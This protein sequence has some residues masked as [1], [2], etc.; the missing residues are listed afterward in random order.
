MSMKV[1][2]GPKFDW[3]DVLDRLIAGEKPTAEDRAAIQ[4][5]AGPWTTCAC[6]QMCK[7][8]PRDSSKSPIDEQLRTLGGEF[9]SMMNAGRYHDARKTLDKIEK[10]TTKLLTDMGVVFTLGGVPRTFR[11]VLKVVPNTPVTEP[12]KVVKPRVVTHGI[13]ERF[14]FRG[15]H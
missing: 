6:G 12:V 1:D 15:G 5:R 3:Y 2:F 9:A 11:R 8:L 14:V 4:Q 10:R 13:A 7:I